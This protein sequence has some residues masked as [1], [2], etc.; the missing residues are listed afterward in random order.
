MKQETMNNED[1]HKYL[2]I[3]KEA[4]L[5]VGEDLAA[6]KWNIYVEERYGK[7]IKIS[8]DCKAEN[9]IINI[10]ETKLNFNIVTEEKGF[11]ELNKKKDD[12][13]WI[14]DP[15]DGSLNYY[16]GIPYCC[17]SIGLW[18]RLEP[19][20]GVVYDFNRRELF[21]GIVGVGAWMNGEQ[22]VTS[23]IK[24]KDIAVIF[25]GFPSSTDYSKDSLAKYIEHVR[26]YSKVRLL[27]SAALSLAYVATGRGDAYY[28]CDIKIWD[29]AA[30]L[31]ILSSA[32]GKYSMEEKNSQTFE[33]NATNGFIE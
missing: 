31:A 23:K 14:V 9:K 29:V 1:L 27:G 7:D 12:L 5:S 21:T 3:A 11:I 15:L 10:L 22:I 26:T 30:A 25:T 33:V 19:I 16:R 18:Y 28:E 32:G 24:A 6:R 2:M 17:V 8:A 20:L 4:T 13:Y